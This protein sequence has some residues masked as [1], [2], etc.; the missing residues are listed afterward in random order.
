MS[1]DF[2]NFAEE[3]RMDIENRLKV[4]LSRMT[5]LRRVV[6]QGFMP[7]AVNVTTDQGSISLTILQDGTIR[8]AKYLSSN[9]DNTI[10][11]NFETL[12]NLIRSRDRNQLIQAENEGKIKIISNS[13]I[14]QKAER[15]IKELL[16]Y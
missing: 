1:S 14:G 13:P 12:K 15:K 6:L 16:G 4:A 3:F 10:Q 2:Y 11:A 9:P 8:L 5:F 7:L